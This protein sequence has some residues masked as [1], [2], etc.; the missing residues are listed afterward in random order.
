MILFSLIAALLSAALLGL[1]A[2]WLRRRP[3]GSVD[4]ARGIYEGFVADLDRRVAAGHL[5][6]AM[7]REEKTEAARALLKASEGEAKASDPRIVQTVGLIGAFAI[8][9][10]ALALYLFVG[11]PGAPDQPYA[12]RLNGWIAQANTNPETLD[13]KPLAEVL[14]RRQAEHGNDPQYW[15]MLGRMQ[16]IAGDHYDG[17]VSFQ[18]AVKLAPQNAE[19][20]S[21]MGEALTLMNKGDS[22]AE[23]RDAFAEA[24]KRDPNDLSGLFYAGKIAAADG[25][26]DAAR[27]FFQRL[28]NVL[29]ADDGR[30]A[31]VVQEV[32][33]L[34]QAA[35]TAAV[36][37]SQIGGMVAG[38]EARL[39]ATPDDPD[40]WARLLRSYRVLKNVE[41]ERHVLA[42]IDRI[43]AD[44]PDVAKRI[45]ETAQRPVGS[46]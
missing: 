24:L 13:A 5:D 21:N 1:A 6:E 8:A 26:F 22:G 29:P 37:Q 28:L 27:G 32:A 46:Q 36:T 3:T 38:L 25:Q 16:V 35:Q 19:A 12:Q 44:R 42:D 31:T 4:T 17:A 39:K 40:G 20:W 15:M 23:A 30:R 14:K 11:Q 45:L 43:Y 18:R 33:A 7:A 10:G 2:A 34:D 41:G 9:G